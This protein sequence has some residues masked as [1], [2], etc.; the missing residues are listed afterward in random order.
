MESSPADQNQPGPATATGVLLP[1]DSSAAAA[2]APV[3]TDD[4]EALCSRA[5]SLLH[6]K[7]SL[8]TSSDD[9]SLQAGLQKFISSPRNIQN[10]SQLVSFLHTAGTASVPVRY[11]SGSAIRV[12]PTAVARHQPGVTR[13]S[14]CALAG[15]PAKLP[16]AGASSRATK[17][18]RSLA[19]NIRDYGP[20]KN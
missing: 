16:A 1:C 20:Q 9:S 15:R 7:V 17:R 14:C 8:L 12:Q 11:R 4:T 19:F 18:P 10:Q 2:T 6:E 13:G 3:C 5:C